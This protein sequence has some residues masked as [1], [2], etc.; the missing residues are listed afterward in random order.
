MEGGLNTLQQ[1]QFIEGA[2]PLDIGHFQP[3]FFF[4]WMDKTEKLAVKSTRQKGNVG[5]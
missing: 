2:L 3:H 4:R 5:Q 1:L